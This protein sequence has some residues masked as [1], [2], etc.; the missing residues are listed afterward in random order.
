MNVAIATGR[1]GEEPSVEPEGQSAGISFAIPLAT[2]ENV[3]DQVIERGEVSRGMLG[4]VMDRP[5]TVGT[6]LDFHAGVAIDRVTEDGPARLEGLRSGDVIVEVGRQPTPSIEVLRSVVTA[7]R[8]G[9]PVDV[10]VWRDDTPQT[11]QVT[12]GVYPPEQLL[13]EM[14]RV[15]LLERGMDLSDSRTD[16]I[17]IR[18]VNP[19]SA[20]YE[21]GFRPGAS[22]VAVGD[23]PV[24]SLGDFADALN[25]AGLFRYRRVTV[26]IELAA[27]D[28]DGETRK[29]VRMSLR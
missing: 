17:V 23:D 2:I 11:M 6:A 19:R 9:V 22:I 4:V 8:P 24:S 20:M 1:N 15:S 7:M 27:P 28:T 13:S 29:R 26:T 16:P 25:D 12:L 10:G 18:N 5:V 3:V 14:V 21:A